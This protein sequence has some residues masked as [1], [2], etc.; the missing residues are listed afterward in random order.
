MEYDIA[1]ET[2]TLEKD[3]TVYL[4][5]FKILRGRSRTPAMREQ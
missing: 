1:I 5:A 4:D 3:N 2:Q